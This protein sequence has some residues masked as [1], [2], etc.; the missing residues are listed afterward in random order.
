MI[1]E[2]ISV[3]WLGAAGVAV[4]A[5]GASVL[6]AALS[7]V[8]PVLDARHGIRDL[9]GVDVGSLIDR[10]ASSVDEASE[11]VNEVESELAGALRAAAWLGRF[12]S[13]F[14]WFP[15][16][17][18]EMDSWSTQG[19]RIEDDLATATVMLDS[20]SR[21]LDVYSGA[22]SS[23]FTGQVT[24]AV[25]ALR[26]V[27]LEL[28]G[29]FSETADAVRG[30]LGGRAF[31]IVQQLPRVNDLF[32]ML[33]DVEDRMLD[34]SG[35]GREVSRL[36]LALLELAETSQPLLAQFAPSGSESP[37]WTGETLGTSL[38]SIAEQAG[39]A[40]DVRRELAVLVAGSGHADEL[41]PRLDAL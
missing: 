30:L 12:S 14:A 11:L 16:A 33:A 4:V 29:S 32:D 25:P 8:P 5:L 38:T 40:E 23:V 34:A 2:K 36:M 1:G 27:S 37:D 9:R 35:V 3:L 18:Q 21:L 19:R 31:G 13:A 20:S 17:R 41:L 7:I 24:S 15:V 6:F 22:S 10:D 28:E 39:A 26:T